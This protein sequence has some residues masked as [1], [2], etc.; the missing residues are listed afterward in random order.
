MSKKPIFR[1]RRLRSLSRP[2]PYRNPSRRSL[3]SSRSVG[4]PLLRALLDGLHVGVANV[5]SAG[6]ILYGNARFAEIFGTHTGELADAHFTQFVPVSNLQELQLALRRG[7]KGPAEGELK[8]GTSSGGSRTIHLS[9]APIDIDGHPT[10]MITATDVTQLIEKNR[11]LRATEESLRALSARIL[12]LQD[13]E[14]RRIAR[15][16]HDITGQELAVVVM[17]LNQLAK[18]FGSPGV[19]TRAILFDAVSL[20]RKVEDEIRTLSYL[21]HPPLLD[22]FGLRSALN[23]YAEGFTK[24][25][26]IAVTVD[27]P[28]DL[29]RL[30]SEKEMALFRVVQESLT[31]VMRHA[32]ASKASIRIRIQG[33]RMRLF[34]EDEGRG[35]SP[36]AFAKISEGTT[37]GVGTQGMR[38]RIQQ[39]GGTLKFRARPRG[40]A[41]VATLPVDD[42]DAGPQVASRAR[43]SVLSTGSAAADFAAKDKKRTL[44]ADDHDVT[45]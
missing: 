2:K 38:E 35:V 21:L 24:R 31:N 26:G 23:W 39:L 29:P 27:I 8:L 40:I 42:R 22:E 6:T 19:N 33:G 4:E 10:V 16:L 36:E 11:T 44:I 13:Q 45:R 18:T 3:A 17:F 7:M 32:D 28:R 43:G 9:L 41:V 5:S 37:C 25:S 12:Q 1:A 20:V 34:V 14:R 30:S 15:D